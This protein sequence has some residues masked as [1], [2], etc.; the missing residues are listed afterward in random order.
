[1]ATMTRSSRSRS[2]PAARGKTAAR[3]K[4]VER[5]GKVA[6]KRVAAAKSASN[7]ARKSVRSS[8]ASARE[9]A[10]A[11][12]FGPVLS[13]L[14]LHCLDKNCPV[15]SA[16]AEDGASILQFSQRPDRMNWVSVTHGLSQAK[17]ADRAELLLQWRIR[18]AKLPVRVLAEAARYLLQTGTQL[19]PGAML[20]A[21]DDKPVNCGISTLPHW[22]VCL[23]D[24]AMLDQLKSLDSSLRVLLLVGITEGELQSALRVRP[25]IADG[26]RVL[27]EA[28][29]IGQVYPITDPNRTCLTRRRDFHRV[30]ESAFQ[31][32]RTG[33]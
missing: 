12:V 9:K 33:K 1:M 16:A 5:K 3:R 31:L 22:M 13:K 2:K 6:S 4:P 7:A 19:A 18:D 24:K 11:E 14:T 17:S 27:F 25:E 30:W 29:R 26:R 23:P 28:L 21:S 32:V 20:S 8:G 10:L 15:L